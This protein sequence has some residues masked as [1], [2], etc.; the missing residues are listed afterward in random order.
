MVSSIDEILPVDLS[1]KTPWYRCYVRDVG[2]RD[3]KDDEWVRGND[4]ANLRWGHDDTT[5]NYGNGYEHWMTPDKD[6][7]ADSVEHTRDYA[8]IGVVRTRYA[9]ETVRYT[10]KDKDG[11]EQSQVIEVK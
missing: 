6:D 8:C 1:D 7:S 11:N 10:E 4:A 5:T 3:P 2:D 9:E